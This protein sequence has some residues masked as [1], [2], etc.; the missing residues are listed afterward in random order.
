MTKYRT[1]LLIALVFLIVVVLLG[2]GL[3]LGQLFKDYYIDSFYE[4]LE[5]EGN[6]VSRYIEDYGGLEGTDKQELGKFGDDLGAGIILA[7]R[8]GNILYS[9]REAALNT[10]GMVKDAISGKKE[11]KRFFN[12]KDDQD[13]HYYWTEISN[14]DITEGYLFLSLAS[15]ELKDAYKNIWWLLSISLFLALIIITLLGMRITKRYAKPIES[16]ANVAMELAKGNYRARTYVEDKVDETGLLSSSINVLARNLED[17]ARSQEMQQERLTTLI[18]NIGSGL[19]LIDSRGFINLINRGYSD[20]FDVDSADVLNKQYYEAIPYPEINEMIET[21]FI[22][23]KKQHAQV[24]LPISIERRH[25]DV[26]ALP[27]ISTHSVWKG[28]LLVFHDITELKKLE[29]VR[30]DF[31]ANVSHELKT[32]ITSIKGFTETLLD[33]AMNDEKA[34][35]DF[36]SIIQKESDRI[37]HLIQ[38]LLDLSKIEQHNFR[39]D[40]SKFDVVSLVKEVTTLLEGRA[41]EKNITVNVFNDPEQL[42]ME[43]DPYRLKQVIIN[44]MSNAIAYTPRD[45]QIEVTVQD[46]GKRVRLMVKDNGMGI[47]PAEIPRIFERFYR[48]DRDRSRNSGGTGLGLAIVKHIVEAH[49]GKIVVK[50]NPGNGSEFILEFRKSFRGRSK[51]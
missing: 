46:T 26:S 1:R 22:T 35:R 12:L 28:V 10:E 37:Q 30:K 3:L 24:V 23:E 17:M 34:L 48:V 45:G 27:I 38:D 43:G 49:H 25:F 5:K 21:I 20:I 50:S 47:A 18:E 40:I 11:R 14:G 2:L 31:V 9:S 7:D 8:K 36:L 6:L 41:T 33:G 16:A 44:L 32:P 13:T 15:S 42:E 19:V 4:R 51:R 39:L 29:Q